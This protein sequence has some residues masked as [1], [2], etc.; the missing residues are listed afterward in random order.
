MESPMTWLIWYATVWFGWIVSNYPWIWG[1]AETLHFVGLALLIGIT[2]TG[3]NGNQDDNS[4][5]GAG[6]VYL[7]VR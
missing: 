3:V 1:I 2:G 4:A 7:F 5:S 6:A